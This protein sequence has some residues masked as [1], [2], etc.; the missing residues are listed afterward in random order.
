MKNVKMNINSSFKSIIEIREYMKNIIS[1]L[2]IS[3]ISKQNYTLYSRRCKNLKCDFEIQYALHKDGIFHLTKCRLNHCVDCKY[4]PNIKS[5]FSNKNLVEIVEKIF[6]SRIPDTKLI[7]DVLLTHGISIS[8]ERAKYIRNIARLLST[9][10]SGEIL[11]KIIDKC[12]QIQQKGWEIKQY[13]EMGMLTAIKIIPPWSKSFL[14]VFSSP[15]MLD[16]TFIDDNIKILILVGI[17][18]E[19]CTQIL[20]VVI[21]YTEDKSGYDY[22][23]NEV[24][25]NVGNK[26]I[27]LISDMAK[28]IH[29]S[30]KSIFGDNV[31]HMYCAFHVWENYIRKINH[32]PSFEMK[33]N[34]YN[35]YRGEISII[36][37]LS[38]IANEK[39]FNSDDYVYFHDI[40]DFLQ[41][42]ES[43]GVFLRHNITTQRLECLN[44]IIKRYSTKLTMVFDSLIEHANLWYNNAINKIYEEH[45]IL[46]D[47]AIQFI[48]NTCNDYI[49]KCSKQ[50]PDKYC[51]HEIDNL[52]CKCPILSY[53]GIPCPQVLIAC[54]SNKINPHNYVSHLWF[55]ETQR[56][57]FLSEV[58][59]NE[60]NNNCDIISGNDVISNNTCL[61]MYKTDYLFKHNINFNNELNNLISKYEYQTVIP[62]NN[63]F[64]QKSNSRRAKI[65]AKLKKLNNSSINCS[66]ANMLIKFY[67]N[68]TKKTDILHTHS[69]AHK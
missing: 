25:K 24:K 19:N 9:G 61:I 31:I 68:S 62:S 32:F 1:E 10:K 6:C 36:D 46:T 39:G 18:G 4:D 29:S 50:D 11:T 7:M 34:F 59:Y 55:I 66:K 27:T 15:I 53:T 47:Y 42:P 8:N 41:V 60:N 69:K 64:K 51:S 21:S 67:I 58:I 63:F 44:G 35:M 40:S 57:A 43:S 30:A 12:E 2:S 56:K 49:C 14:S 16:A 65:D 52:H 37:F 17:D 26:K 48:H 45:Q 22:L 5:N 13:Y 33:T 54:I 20:G 38:S 23:L 28:C 3:S